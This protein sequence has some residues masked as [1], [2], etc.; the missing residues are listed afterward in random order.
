MKTKI[1]LVL[2]VVLLFT[3][4]DEDDN[5]LKCNTYSTDAEIDVVCDCNEA[6]EGWTAYPNE[7]CYYKANNTKTCPAGSTLIGGSCVAGYIPPVDATDG[8]VLNSERFSFNG[9]TVMGSSYWKRDGLNGYIDNSL[10][11]SF[12]GA[13]SPNCPT[14]LHGPTI[15]YFPW[16]NATEVYTPYPQ[17]VRAPYCP[18]TGESGSS[19]VTVQEGLGIGMYTHAGADSRIANESVLQA[20]P[21]DYPGGAGLVATYLSFN[22]SWILE[23]WTG[24]NETVALVTEQFVPDTLI[25]DNKTQAQQNVRTVFIN[26]YCYAHIQP[27]QTCQFSWN[28]Q[29]Y[30]EGIY[31]E[32]N[33]AHVMFDPA[34]GG[35]AVILGSVETSPYWNSMGAPTQRSIYYGAKSFHM[36]M[37]WAQGQNLLIE[38][39]IQ[40]F[41][42]QGIT[43]E[44]V[45]YA[46]VAAHFG[47]A[48]QDKNEWIIYSIGGGQE[49]FNPIKT[50]TAYM[51][52]MVKSLNIIAR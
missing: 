41:A 2:S 6:P 23:P 21:L 33:S 9:T 10:N 27:G 50:D 47:D 40:A 34:Q 31:T 30:M 39:T 13:A 45:S 14:K 37:S 32:D 42:A 12:W 52:G 46:E 28:T 17:V 7:I 11:I 29:L 18:E 25:D 26:K 22:P 19:Y 5:T 51:S 15:G 1:L 49:V 36:E 35:L 48:W 20:Y 3:S 38:F 44:T 4:C 43:R 16:I 8:V 24:A